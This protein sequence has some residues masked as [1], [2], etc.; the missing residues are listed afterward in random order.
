[1]IPLFYVVIALSIGA[2][3]VTV[4]ALLSAPEG[5][6]DEEG[7]HAIRS[8]AVHRPRANSTHQSGAGIQPR[9]FPR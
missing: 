1:M 2:I 3:A 7:F 4:R 8:R 9:L 5:Y 6:E